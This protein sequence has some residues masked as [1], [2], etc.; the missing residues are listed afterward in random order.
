MPDFEP[1]IQIKD[2]SY[3]PVGVEHDILKEIN[4]E[5]NPGDFALLLGPPGCGKSMLTRCFNGI[6]PHI[7]EGKMSGTVLVNGK[8]TRKCSMHEFAT[9]I[10]MVFQNPDDQIVSLKV[11]DEVAWGVE[12]L[13]LEHEEI[14]RRVYRFM[15]MLA[16][17]H[18]KDRLT[19]AISGGQKQK[20]SI[21]SNLAMLQDVLVLDD[22]T[23]DLDPVC[24]NEVVVALEQLHR[25]MKKTLVVIEHDLTDLIEMA[26]RLIVMEDGRIVH[27]GKPGDLFTNNYEDLVRL[28]INLPQ[29]IEI[30]HAVIDLTGKEQPCPTHKEDAFKVLET[31]IDS[32]PPVS[33]PKQEAA[34]AQAEAVISVR[35]LEF[36]Y[37]PGKKILKDINF[38]IYHGQFVAIVGANGSGKSTLVNHFTGL[39]QPDKGSIT[40]NG[41]DTRQTKVNDLAQDI[42]YVFQNPDHQLFCNTVEEEVAFSLGLRNLPEE[43]IQKRITEVLEFVQLAD[44]R[45]RHPFSLSRGQRQKLA[46]ATALIHQPSVILLDEPTT[47]Q[48][49]HSLSGLLTLMTRLNK[50]GNTT[51]MITHDM[52]IVTA[53]ANRVLIMVD[54][55]IAMDGRPVDVFYENF[56]A[57]ND[58]NL[59]PPAVIDF[60]RRLENKG[61][62]R[63]LKVE[64]LKHYLE[65]VKI[66][67]HH[68]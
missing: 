28:G 48:D 61:V 21:A 63:C 25:D 39:L 33:H 65:E 18:L 59:R 40:I 46:V 32:Y 7:D 54:G 17:T 16:I 38:D 45:Q 31:Y 52:D 50:Q 14:Q 26:T 60:C 23:T 53:Y 5:I 13:G 6:V 66:A 34:P 30:A 29:H 36:S 42:G 67:N 10:G 4:L 51:I 49:R 2:L 8:D 68:N 20:V 57:L 1:I 19:F 41:H 3:A 35:D 58:L 22:P 43:E 47:G 56:N 62:P 9:I 37:L 44:F 15:D 12:N 27:D 64:E 24:K 11:L 55:Q